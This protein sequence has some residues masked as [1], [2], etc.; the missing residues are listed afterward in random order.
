MQAAEAL[1]NALQKVVHE[2]L[3]KGSHDRRVLFTRLRV[4]PQQVDFMCSDAE[5]MRG[6]VPILEKRAGDLPVRAV[7]LPDAALQ[8]RTAWVT[9]SV[10]DVRAEPRHA[11]EQI[12]QA[13]QGETLEP[14]LAE[15]GWLLARL[16]DGYLGWIRDW[17]LQLTTA[18]DTQRFSARANATV[19]VDTVALRDAASDDAQVCA[20]TILGT[21]VAILERAQGRVEIELPGGRRGWIDATAVVDGT[22]TWPTEVNAILKTLRRFTG[23]PYVWGG[24]SPKGFDC[25]GFVQFVFG[26][27]GVDLPRDS[28]QQFHCGTPVT[29]LAP[30]DLLF[31]GR[32]SIG[33]VGVVTSGSTFVHAR[34]EVRTN[35][36]D[37]ASP[38]HD[39]DLA[40]QYRGARRLLPQNS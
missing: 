5:A 19:V 29:D 14:L 2:T 6:V 25:S 35:A 20:E 31:F 10:A 22:S 33:H 30:C 26:L 3:E 37:P 13:L 21:R 27:H 16:S 39:T 8:G 34:G 17:H 40:A 12:T 15:D 11:A 24:K 23:V 38:I 1:Q 28:D 32:D 36:L 9:A 4:S 18:N 7:E